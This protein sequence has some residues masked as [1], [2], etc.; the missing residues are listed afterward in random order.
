MAIYPNEPF[1]SK[2]VLQPG[3]RGD[4]FMANMPG[5]RDGEKNRVQRTNTSL[6]VSEHDVPNC[7]WDLDYRL[8]VLFRYGWG[9]GFNQIIS[10]KG[11]IFALDP[12]MNT[13]DFETKKQHNTCTLANGG[14]PVRLR[15]SSDEYFLPKT[16]DGS[17]PY[18]KFDIM[19]PD[20]KADS[21]T[22]ENVGKD[23]IPLVGLEKAYNH[24]TYRPFVDNKAGGTDVVT[25]SKQ[26]TNA[27]YEIDKNTGKVVKTEGKVDAKD[28]RPGNIPIG[29]LERN[30]YTRDID[31]YNG[32][33]PGPFRTDAL[34]EL[35]WFYHK[36]KA[37]KNV[38]GSAYG[39][40]YPG[41]LVK[42]DENGRVVLSPLSSDAD[43]ATMSVQEIELERRQVIG[44]I[45][46]ATQELLPEGAAKWAT[47]ALEDRINYEGFNPTV[48]R[49]TNRQ[50]EDTTNVSPYNSTGEYPGYPFDKAFNDSNLHM[51]GA[52]LRNNNYNQR[53]DME[54]QYSELGIPGLTD[55]YNVNKRTIPEV[56]VGEI[57]HRGNAAD[58]V[59]VLFR[60]L[61]VDVENIMIKLDDG[62]AVTATEGQELKDGAFVVSYVNNLQGIVKLKINKEKA[63]PILETKP[64]EVFLSCEKRGLAGVPTFMD[65]DGCVGSVK[66]LLTK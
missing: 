22:V 34:V 46:S 37:E 25:A 61:E 45:Y 58:Y 8:P 19:S 56:K 10:P 9:Y 16:V 2:E 60:T 54:Y 11:R 40:L 43:V 66:V 35:P 13:V 27:G 59:E 6:N 49:A 24:F 39:N 30:E 44:E 14:V 47:W 15:K 17:D 18:K 20:V 64:V 4:Q 52:N 32:M 31:A 57:H 28:V 41:A 53:M 50:N 1:A 12:F 63:D 26:L 21:K 62:Q 36:D 33:M 5:F 7:K 38:W 29:I 51:M 55:G 23:W 48:Y 42:S 3:A 65:W